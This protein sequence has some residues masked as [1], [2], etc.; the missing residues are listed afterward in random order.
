[1][2]TVLLGRKIG[3]TRVYDDEGRV[4]PVTVVEASGNV[5]LQR[6]TEESDGYCAVQI[7][8]HDKRESRSNR[9]EVAHCKKFGSE[10][11]RW[12]REV[13]LDNAESVEAAENPSVENF[14]AGQFVDVIGE[15]K[16]RGFQGVMKRYGFA[17][18]PAS[19][20]SKMH[21]RTGSV[22]QGST[23]GLVWK[24]SKMPGQMGN[25]RVTIQNLKIIQVRPEHG[26]IL[27]EGSLPGAKGDF[28]MVRPAKKKPQT[29]EESK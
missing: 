21:R 14:A 1:M 6:K 2:S 11:K 28:L 26:L 7:G 3:M 29:S 18:Q 23:P 8:Y 15:S 17:G 24:N 13:R 4:H 20:G 10:P 25:R 19:H 5:V 12:I 22:G 9:P 16:G 27:I